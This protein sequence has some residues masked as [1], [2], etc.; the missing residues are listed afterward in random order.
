MP[1]T[2]ASRL[3][4]LGHRLPE[5]SAPAANYVSTV[6][7]GNLLVIS[8]QISVRND[9]VLMGI[10]G[11][12]VSVEEGRLAAEC[13]AIGVLSQIAAAT[14]G[15]LA[16]IRRIVRLGVFIASAPDFAEQSQVA[17]G[18]SDLFVEVFGDAG[19]HAR[20]AVGVAALPAGATVEVD[21]LVELET[22][23]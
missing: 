2:I 9:A 7:T 13:A 19:R 18:A 17:N 3:S 21:A 12:G 4:A 14:D 15:S 20:A 6:R 16:A 5:A 22:A 10:V 23:A 11:A 1:E 8:G